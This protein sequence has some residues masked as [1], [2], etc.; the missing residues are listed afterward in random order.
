MSASVELCEEQSRNTV[1][2]RQVERHNS[3][4][5]LWQKCILR[6]LPPFFPVSVL[7]FVF[8]LS[9]THPILSHIHTNAHTAVLSRSLLSSLALSVGIRLICEQ[10]RVSY[11]IWINDWCCFLPAYPTDIQKTWF[12]CL[13]R[14]TTCNGR[15]LH[16]KTRANQKTSNC[17]LYLYLSAMHDSN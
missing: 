17:S 8:S 16:Q 6:L 3:A 12:K 11:L 13:T 5:G 9:Y 7:C 10:F 15:E 2:A 14:E 4:H 1:W